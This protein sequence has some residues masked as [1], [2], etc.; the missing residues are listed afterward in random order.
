MRLVPSL[1]GFEGILVTHEEVFSIADHLPIRGDGR[2]VYR[3][4]VMFV[5]PPCNDAML[6]GLPCRGRMTGE[7]TDW[8]RPEGRGDRQLH[9]EPG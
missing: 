9:G 5:N 1:G 4:T 8:T 3:P 7:Y 2:S 6:S